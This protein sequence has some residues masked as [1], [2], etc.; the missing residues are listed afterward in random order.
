MLCGSSSASMWACDTRNKYWVVY[1]RLTVLPDETVSIWIAPDDISLYYQASL[2]ARQRDVPNL[3]PRSARCLPEPE[4]ARRCKDVYIHMHTDEESKKISDGF[5]R[6]KMTKTVDGKYVMTDVKD[7]EATYKISMVVVAPK[8]LEEL[9]KE[10]AEFIA[11]SNL[12]N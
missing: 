9:Q 1:V 5:P 8:T 6:K 3:Q 10:R 7:P 4:D 11:P 12:V 2:Q